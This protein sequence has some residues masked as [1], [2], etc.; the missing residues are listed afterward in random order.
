[1]SFNRLY[2]LLGRQ[3]DSARVVSQR[4]SS[5]S[6]RGS[7]MKATIFVLL[8]V[9]ALSACAPAIVAAP[10]ATS[11]PATDVPTNAAISSPE[12]TASPVALAPWS[13]VAVGDSI[14]YNSSED[15]PGCTGSV[16]RYATAITKATGHPVT[17]QNLSQHNGLQTDS[18]LEELKTDTT[19]REALA[20]ADI[21]I[22]SIGANDT[23]YRDNVDD[24]CDGPSGANPDWSKF[25]TTCAAAAAEIFR[26]KFEGVYAQIVALRAGKPTIFRT[27]NV[28]NEWITLPGGY[29]T[30]KDMKASRVVLD[31]WNAMICKA[32]QANGFTCADIYHAF[33][34]PDGLKPALD[35]LANDHS[36]P[37]DKGNDVIARVLA[38]LGYAP[39]AQ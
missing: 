36:H 1:M 18:L 4:V 14:P 15:C 23:A 2:S 26:P 11:I 9:V 20:N 30:P 38:D 32:A 6:T 25:N 35:L 34:G 31:A 13:L 17:V 5:S 16:D 39:L 12:P 19:R 7:A 24:P 28:Y 3:V 8:L 22:V 33:N 10:V 21:I 27:I 29:V 37:S